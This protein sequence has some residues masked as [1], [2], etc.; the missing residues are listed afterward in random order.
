MNVPWFIYWLLGFG[1][2]GFGVAETIAVRSKRRGDT[3]SENV[4]YATTKVP[5]GGYLLTA[6]LGWLAW[7]FTAGRGV[8]WDFW[9][10]DRD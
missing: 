8:R 4:H 7:H 3:L 9:R 6:L 10:R 2:I 5:F 1:V